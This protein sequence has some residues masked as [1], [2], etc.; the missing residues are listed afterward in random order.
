MPYQYDI[1]KDM[2]ELEEARLNANLAIKEI[3]T[4]YRVKH[5]VLEASG[6]LTPEEF[7]ALEE[8]DANNESEDKRGVLRKLIDTILEKIRNFIN[9]F[10]K[11]KAKW[12]D[13]KP[14]TEIETPVSEEDLRKY[15]KSGEFVSQ[16]LD[17]VLET[18]Q[19]SDMEAYKSAVRE[20]EEATKDSAWM[21]TISSQLVAD[22]INDETKKSAK[23]FVVKAAVITA[24]IAVVNKISNTLN[25]IISLGNDKLPGTIGSLFGKMK[26]NKEEVNEE[27]QKLCNMAT[28]DLNHMRRFNKF[29][30]KIQDKTVK[31]M[32]KNRTA[33]NADATN[34]ELQNQA[35][36][37]G[38]GESNKSITIFGD[39]WKGKGI[40]SWI[41]TALNGNLKTLLDHNDPRPAFSD[42]GKLDTYLYNNKGLM[43][44]NSVATVVSSLVGFVNGKGSKH[45][46][47]IYPGFINRISGND[48]PIFFDLWGIR[49][50]P[51]FFKFF[52]TLEKYVEFQRN[53][54]KICNEY[55]SKKNLPTISWSDERAIQYIKIIVGDKNSET[56]KSW[57]HYIEDQ[58]NQG[59]QQSGNQNTNNTTD[60]QYTFIATYYKKYNLNELQ[61]EL[62]DLEETDKKHN[63]SNDFY[64][65]PR[66]SVIQDF[67]LEENEIEEFWDNFKKYDAKKMGIQE[68]SDKINQISKKANHYAK[69]N[70][71]RWTR[72]GM[73]AFKDDAK[74]IHNN[75]GLLFENRLKKS[76]WSD[77]YY[78]KR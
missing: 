69:G 17:K 57:E 28:D 31:N 5:M 38:P 9:S 2:Y 68:D 49:Y 78:L 22:D 19:G 73:D 42:G 72:E 50:R 53:L 14:D 7:L 3:E 58:N 15:I 40:I 65:F 70:I 43:E 16:K 20:Y 71:F 25:D 18:A 26:A 64:G 63:F 11:D 77:K 66:S 32:I 4:K 54:L 6:Q 61:K 21:S 39:Q 29:I 76:G 46:N 55:R 51:T 48:R 10:K 47:K 45:Q 37:D 52:N 59:N 62:K 27:A 12:E 8:E 24:A 44:G 35:E 1:D 30:K 33:K 34:K 41:N 36:D 56:G 23:R 13:I 75:A 74:S 60:S 67:P